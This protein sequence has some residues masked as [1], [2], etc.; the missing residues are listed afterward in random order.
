MN[1]LVGRLVGEAK[2][3]R[4]VSPGVQNDAKK[5]PKRRSGVQND[6]QKGP[7]MTGNEPISG[8]KWVPANRASEKK[9]RRFPGGSGKK[10][11]SGFLSLVKK[12]HVGV[13]VFCH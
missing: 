9:P 10:P 3:E 13:L 11:L 7:K 8:P 12:N 6:T 2:R 4:K 1:G 5:G